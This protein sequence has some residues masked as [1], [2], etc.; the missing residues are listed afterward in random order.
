[1]GAAGDSGVVSSPEPDQESRGC[2][3]A[4]RFERETNGERVEFAE[5]LREKGLG[6]YFWKNLEKKGIIDYI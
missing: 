4:A 6:F 3:M 5:K 2:E 1:V